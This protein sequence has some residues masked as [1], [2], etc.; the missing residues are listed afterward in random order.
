VLNKGV[1]QVELNQVFI[2]AKA[3]LVKTDHAT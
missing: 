3:W 2:K 1:E